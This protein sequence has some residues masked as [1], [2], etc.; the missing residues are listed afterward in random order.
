MGASGAVFL[1]QHVIDGAELGQ[2]ATAA[3]SPFTKDLSL[4]HLVASPRSLCRQ[5]DRCWGVEDISH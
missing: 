4:T 5:E 1:V 2:L 3:F